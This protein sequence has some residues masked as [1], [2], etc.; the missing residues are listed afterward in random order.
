MMAVK[1]TIGTYFYQGQQVTVHLQD[2]DKWHVKPANGSWGSGITH[3]G[4]S[5]AGLTHG[6][7]VSESALQS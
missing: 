6:I 7:E 4:Q 3:N 1:S 5:I 2:G